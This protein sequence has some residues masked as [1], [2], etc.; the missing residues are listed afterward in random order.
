MTAVLAQRLSELPVQARQQ[1]A[2]AAQAITI[3]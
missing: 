1:L 3:E 2:R